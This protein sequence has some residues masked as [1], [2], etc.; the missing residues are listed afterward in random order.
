MSGTGE[1]VVEIGGAKGAVDAE[2]LIARDPDSARWVAVCPVSNLNASGETWPE[3]TECMDEVTGLLFKILHEAGDLEE[4]LRDRGWELVEP[5]P[6]EA[7]SPRFALPV[8][9]QVRELPDL[10]GAIS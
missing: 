2:W 4:F 7:E 9:R 10:V 5:V 8:N 3:L 1:L 6:E